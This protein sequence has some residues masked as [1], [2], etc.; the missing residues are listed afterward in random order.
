M[1]EGTGDC[2][3]GGIAWER[4]LVWMRFF[5][6]AGLRSDVCVPRT[7]IEPCQIRQLARANNISQCMLSHKRPLYIPPNLYHHLT[8]HRVC[9]VVAALA[10]AFLRRPS[11][12]QGTHFGLDAAHQGLNRLGRGMNANDSV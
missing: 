9:A 4:W 12:G 3:C 1:V 10:L 5:R 6:R 8:G 11:L 2:V 7:P